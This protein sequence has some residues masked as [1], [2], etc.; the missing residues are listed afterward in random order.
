MSLEMGSLLIYFQLSLNTDK[1][2]FESSAYR[3][4]GREMNA[5]RHCTVLGGEKADEALKAL[6][7]GQTDYVSKILGC[8]SL[9]EIHFLKL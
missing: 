6:L 5:E 4:I 3:V 7:G 2:N 1:H 8:Q 9:G